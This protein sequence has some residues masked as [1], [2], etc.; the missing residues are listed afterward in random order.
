M[1]KLYEIVGAFKELLEM[2][3]EENMD[4]KLISDQKVLNLSLKKRQMVTQK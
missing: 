2:A 3:S 1:A 4:Q